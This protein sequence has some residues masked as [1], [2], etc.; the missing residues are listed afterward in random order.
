MIDKKLYL[1]QVIFKEK[2][3][4]DYREVKLSSIKERN[5]Y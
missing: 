5:I 4:N 2:E 1:I 3:L